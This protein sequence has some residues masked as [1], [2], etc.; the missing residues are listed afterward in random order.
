M[1]RHSLY[2][3]S[4]RTWPLVYS[5]ANRYSSGSPSTWSRSG[6][7]PGRGFEPDWRDSDYGEPELIAHG[8]PDRLAA[9]A[10]HVHVGGLAAPVD[11]REHLVRGEEAERGDRDR[12]AERDTEQRIAGMV[13]AKVQAGE[14]EQRDEE[15]EAQLRIGPGTA[16]DD[17]AVCDPHQE[18][19]E[20]RHRGRRRR[21]TA[22]AADD[23]HPVRARP[24][25]AEVNPLP[26][27]LKEE[28]AAHEHQEVSP[29]PESHR[30]GDRR[31]PEHGD[32]PAGSGDLDPVG[33]IGQPRRPYPRQQA[34]HPGTEPV[35]KPERRRVLRDQDR[36]G[37]HHGRQDQPRRGAGRE[38]VRQRRGRARGAALAAR[39]VDGR[40]WRQAVRPIP[41]DHDLGIVAQRSALSLASNP[42]ARSQ[43]SATRRGSCSCFSTSA[44]RARSEPVSRRPDTALSAATRPAP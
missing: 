39:A 15:R 33:D 1:L 9:S 20:D 42:C 44:S 22:P 30:Q 26:D 28:Q 7:E 5:L 23:R 31:Q 6:V 4:A 43:L 12:H 19:R 34:K 35:I 25:Q 11:D 21:V 40:A 36:A 17:E 10:G 24:R 37:Q 38:R 16:R 27:L 3:R 32:P 18:D 2:Q 29:S 14:A 13:D 8:L 41:R